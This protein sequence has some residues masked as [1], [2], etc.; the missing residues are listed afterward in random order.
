MMNKSLSK[1]WRSLRTNFLTRENPYYNYGCRV[2]DATTRTII[3]LIVSVL[4][5]IG[6]L[7]LCKIFWY[8]YIAT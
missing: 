8:S 3:M 2:L 6:L 5:N 1:K 4:V 7:Y